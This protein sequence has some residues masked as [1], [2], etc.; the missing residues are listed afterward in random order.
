MSVCSCRTRVTHRMP[1][2]ELK[3]ISE[4]EASDQDNTAIFS[5]FEN[6]SKQTIELIKQALILSKQEGELSA[7]IF[8]CLIKMA[9][10]RNFVLLQNEVNG[11]GF[12]ADTQKAKVKRNPFFMA[13]LESKLKRKYSLKVREF[14]VPMNPCDVQLLQNQP[15]IGQHFRTIKMKN[16]PCIIKCKRVVNVDPKH[17]HIFQTLFKVWCKDESFLRI[18]SQLS[19]LATDIHNKQKEE[20][21]IKQHRKNQQMRLGWR[22]FRMSSRQFSHLDPV[23]IKEEKT[24][25]F[26]TRRQ[27]SV[28]KDKV[29]QRLKTCMVRCIKCRY[30]AAVRN[31]SVRNDST[32]ELDL[33]TNFSSDLHP[34]CVWHPGYVKGDTWTCCQT[35]ESKGGESNCNANH[36]SKTGCSKGDHAWRRLKFSNQ[37]T[38]I[39]PSNQ[40]TRLRK[41]GRAGRHAKMMSCNHCSFNKQIHDDVIVRPI[42]Q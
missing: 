41:C 6:C 13:V 9:K 14:T 8:V 19:A 11:N 7:L 33:S 26:E 3:R 18:K 23:D 27:I 17:G 37:K 24:E 40:K 5:T 31:D 21:R 29:G 30:T 35:T 16:K 2:A 22:Y 15:Q 4:N 36:W 34:E 12:E 32:S 38:R 42:S 20:F 39:K 1:L 10:Q 25:D 28:K